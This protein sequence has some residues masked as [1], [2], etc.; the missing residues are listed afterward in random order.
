MLYVLHLA[1]YDGRSSWIKIGG[2]GFD[3]VPKHTFEQRY[4]GH[5]HEFRRFHRGE[6][7]YLFFVLLDARHVGA[8]EA[9]MHAFCRAR[10]RVHHAF[11]EVYL[12][13]NEAFQSDSALVH[14][15]HRL[16][17]QYRGHAVDE[18][19]KLLRAEER[20]RVLEGILAEYRRY[21]QSH[22]RTSEA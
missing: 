2:H 22:P 7:R 8:A 13:G 9:D 16:Q 17:G 3:R 19:Q 4:R 11:K 14:E 18:H 1:N 21:H 6:M 12:M 15:L 5:L 10:F 20:I